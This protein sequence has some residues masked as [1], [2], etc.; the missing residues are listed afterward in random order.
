MKKKQRRLF[1][2]LLFDTVLEVPASAR[3]QEKGTKGSNI[4]KE[5]TKLCLFADDM[6]IFEENLV[7]SMKKSAR[8]N[9]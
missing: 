7:E 5:E 6:I 2:L 8:A 3:R 9:K 4:G 1:L